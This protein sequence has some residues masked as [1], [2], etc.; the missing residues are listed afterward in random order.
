MEPEKWQDPADQPLNKMQRSP[1]YVVL[2]I[3]GTCLIGLG[4]VGMFYP[5]ALNGLSPRVASLAA[6]NDVALMISG[7]VI[8]LVNGIGGYFRAKEGARE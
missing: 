1:V 4:M 7:G 3:T 8:Y 5:S 2:S 6:E